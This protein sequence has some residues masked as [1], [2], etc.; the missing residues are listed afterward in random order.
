MKCPGPSIRAFYIQIIRL[1]NIPPLP[2]ASR[3]DLPLAKAPQ[4]M[5]DLQSSRNPAI[6]SIDLGQIRKDCNGESKE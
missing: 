5:L 6:Q 1:A 4:K 2:I 3:V